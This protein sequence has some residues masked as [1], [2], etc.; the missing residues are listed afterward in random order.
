MLLGALNDGEL[1]ATEAGNEIVR[2]DKRRN[3]AGG[4]YEHV[5]AD[6]VAE[7]VVDILEPVEV[8]KEQGGE[9]AMAVAIG[10]GLG[11]PALEKQPVGELP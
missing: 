9:P 6:G 3:D 8:D 7:G 2:A 11:Q 10:D 4:L 5:V 1:V